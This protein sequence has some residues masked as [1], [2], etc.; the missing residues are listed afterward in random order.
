MKKYT[1]IILILIT[2][3]ALLY[4]RTHIICQEGTGAFATIAAGIDV[5]LDG[6]T[7]LV[8]PGTY[9]ENIDYDGKDIV[10]TSLYGVESDD[11]S[12]IRET[13]IDGNEE[14]TVVAFKS[15]E[16]R[17]AVLNG[18]TIQNGWSSFHRN[19]HFYSTGGGIFIDESSPVISNCYIENNM[20]YNG[21]GI[22]AQGG[23]NPLL[24]GN[25]IRYNQNICNQGA[26][27]TWNVDL[28]FCT[29]SLNSV[30][31]NYGSRDIFILSDHQSP[32]VVDT[33]TVKNPDKGEFVVIQD[34]PDDFYM[35]VNHGKIEPVAADS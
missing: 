30:Y 31:K 6:D 21:S 13:I 35:T 28:Q 1:L 29:T 27:R 22:F 5:A 4:P 20:G 26:I 18:F 19:C 8:Y 17:N 3:T 9:Y 12:I 11:R 7:L 16:T 33:F 32:I 2:A 10:I 25:I 23:G 15:G 14:G 34:I 24:K